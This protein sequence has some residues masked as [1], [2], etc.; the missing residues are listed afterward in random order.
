MLTIAETMVA[1]PEL[2]LLICASL[3]L[4]INAFVEDA[5][6]RVVYYLTQ[7]S[8]VSCGLLVL[9]QFPDQAPIHAFANHYI[10][11]TMASILKIVICIISGFSLLY[12]YEYMHKYTKF[13]GEFFVLAL[14]AI[15]GIMILVSAHSL[16]TVYLGL[17]LLSLSL[18]SMIAIQ[19]QVSTAIEAALK[20]FVL[21]A[22][23][24]GILLYGMSIIYGV[25]GSLELNA[26]ATHIQDHTENPLLI[27]GLVFILV[28]IA[29]KLGAAP[30][31]MWI[32]DVYQGAS[33][34]ATL[35]IA[36]APKIAAFAM[37]IRLLTNGLQPL[38]IDWQSILIGLS[39]L[40][41]AIGNIV[42]ISQTNIKRMLAY[43][44]IAHMGYLLLGILS[45][46][47]T[48]YAA[49]MFYIISYAVMS[50]GAFSMVVLLSRKNFEA[51]KL[52]HFQG[53][54]HRTPWFAC[55]FLILMFSL[56]GIPPFLGFW[57]KWFVLQELIHAG[58]FEV[59]VI[60]V[61]LSII[62]AYYYLRIIKLM[63]FDRAKSLPAIIASKQMRLAFSINSLALLFFGLAPASIFSICIN[64]F[65]T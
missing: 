50:L 1:A 42:A 40:S 43:S 27:F 2:L 51:E 30:F 32:P 46:T 19:R 62:G 24:S 21:G 34:S 53:L 58:L 13:S 31:H 38:F 4:V 64:A 3:I 63:Y 11:D 56:A 54:A 26:I 52:E 9:F 16:L 29:F 18:Y 33:I 60:A 25:T 23:V 22:L 57:G 41:M 36:S 12:A 10:N 65:A 28:G 59:A 45:G 6:H 48:G 47:E 37:A 5:K 15:L 17:E 35:F 8:L 61:F 39:V 7:L 55:M 20:F 49:S 14:F 44:A